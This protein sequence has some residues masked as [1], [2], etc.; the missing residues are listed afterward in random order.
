VCFLQETYSTKSDVNTWKNQWG[1]DVLYSHG[2]NHS[3]GVMILFKPKVDVVIKECCIDDQ[4][5]YIIVNVVIKGTLV[6]LVNIYAPNAEAEQGIFFENICKQMVD[7][8][9]QDGHVIAGGDMNVILDPVLDRKGGQYKNS[10]QYTKVISSIDTLMEE[11]ELCDIWRV[12]NPDT[13][14]YTWRRREPQ[15]H[16]RLDMWWVSEGG[17]NLRYIAG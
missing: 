3:K 17:G 14:R 1:G 6:Q 4:G 13:R 8:R 16:S 12:L 5:R 10:M 2:S 11:H 9:S 15:V 7:L